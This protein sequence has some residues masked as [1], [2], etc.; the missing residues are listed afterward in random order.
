MEFA[1]PSYFTHISI[2]LPDPDGGVTFE[3]AE[4]YFQK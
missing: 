2:P 4:R 1:P 3:T